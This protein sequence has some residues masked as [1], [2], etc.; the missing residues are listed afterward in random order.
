[1]N[2][3]YLNMIYEQELQLL[4]AQGRERLRRAREQQGYI[5]GSHR[6]GQ[7][8]PPGV[9]DYELHTELLEIQ[10]RQRLRMARQEE[11]GYIV[12]SHHQGQ[13]VAPEL[14]DLELQS[15]L[16]EIQDDVALLRARQQDLEL[17]LDLLEI[18]NKERLLKARQQDLEM[19]LELLEIQNKERSLRA[20]HWWCPQIGEPVE[21]RDNHPHK[22]DN[23]TGSHHQGPGV[24]PELKTKSLGPDVLPPGVGPQ[25]KVNGGR[26]ESHMRPAGRIESPSTT[27]ERI[28]PHHAIGSNGRERSGQ[29][30]GTEAGGEDI[31][32]GNFALDV[33][34]VDF[35]EGFGADLAAH[36][37]TK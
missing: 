8:A 28:S 31:E 10:N 12:G 7:G 16:L 25:L 5:V 4:E 20:R 17:Q 23:I 37:A 19:Q 15:E 18:Q 29:R 11:R 14:E 3:S 24:A 13:G 9:I 35:F 27:T 26:A 30:E 1:M 36:E 22:Q 21:L 32:V 2:N 33:F 6:Q 34:D